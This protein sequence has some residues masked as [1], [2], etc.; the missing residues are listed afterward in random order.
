MR[1]AGLDLDIVKQKINELK[2]KNIKMQINR[3]RKRFIK[4]TG[5]IESTY[6]CVFV[7]RINSPSSVETL[8]YSYS[9]VLCGDV[10]IAIDAT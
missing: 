2:G 5:I 1:K 8:S 7:V 10:K 3:G 4:Y 6:P 9:D